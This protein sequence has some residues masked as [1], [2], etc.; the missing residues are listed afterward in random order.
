MALSRFLDWLDESAAGVIRVAYLL[1]GVIAVASYFSDGNVPAGFAHLLNTGLPWVLAAALEIHTYLTARRVRKAWQD[2]NA[3]VLGS[4]EHERAVKQMKL[5]IWILAA[6]LAF[7]MYNQ[8]QY[9]AQTWTPP[10]LPLTPPG[11]WPYLIRAIITPAAFMAAAFLAPMGEG[12]A[13]QIQ[14]EAH[15]LTAAAFKAASAQ[16]KRRLREMQRTGQ[17]ITSALVELVD[18]PAE[19]RVIA[20]IHRAMHGG[21]AAAPAALPTPATT[22]VLAY[23]ERS[24][25]P[26]GKPEP[27]PPAPDNGP[28]NGPKRAYERSSTR[29]ASTHAPVLVLASEKPRRADAGRRSA[30]A[31]ARWEQHTNLA[32]DLLTVDPIMSTRELARRMNTNVQRA[33]EVRRAVQPVRPTRAEAFGDK[34]DDKKGEKISA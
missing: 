13:V 10:H 1:A 32:A 6:L 16:W 14:S 9:L 24:D 7:S 19:R 2:S 11:A 30:E 34:N 31:Q 15:Y 17:D 25:G 23:S 26:G 18:D 3:S 28:G 12:M 27:T 5:N 4:D 22:P 21:S 8:L 20:T 29:R 33:T